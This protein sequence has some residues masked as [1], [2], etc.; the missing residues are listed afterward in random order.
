MMKLTPWCV[1][2]LTFSAVYIF[3]FYNSATPTIVQLEAV[4]LNTTE[5]NARVP[6][7][8]AIV[9]NS[10]NTSSVQMQE[11]VTKTVCES[12]RNI[13]FLRMYRTGSSTVVNILLRFAEERNL[14]VAVP[15]APINLMGCPIPFKE[16]FMLNYSI[17]M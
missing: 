2:R 1:F 11:M 10:E 5:S 17:L 8:T 4:N 14:T 13:F 12:V 16:R 6:E 7:C 15:R 3:I 9:Q